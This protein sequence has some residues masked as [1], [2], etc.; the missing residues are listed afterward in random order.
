MFNGLSVFFH[1]NPF[2]SVL[3]NQIKTVNPYTV[4]V[5]SLVLLDSQSSPR[6][7]RKTSTK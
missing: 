3:K 2:K 1:S 4:W 6:L 5:G 7:V